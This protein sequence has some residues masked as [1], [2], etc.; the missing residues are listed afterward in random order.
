VRTCTPGNWTAKES[1]EESR[2]EKGEKKSVGGEERS[3]QMK[4]SG[5]K[6]YFQKEIAPA[7]KR[8]QDTAGKKRSDGKEGG[9]RGLVLRVGPSII[10]MIIY[11]MEIHAERRGRE[12]RNWGRK[13]RTRVWYRRVGWNKSPYF[14]S[15]VA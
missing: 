12:G 11:R 3:Y 8:V 6:L 4:S 13:R 5:I 9:G 10:F 7:K 15:V 14:E 1:T 2:N